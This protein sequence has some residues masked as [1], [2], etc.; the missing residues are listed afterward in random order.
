MTPNTINTINKHLLKQKQ[1]QEKV[2]RQQ[3]RQLRKA[4]NENRVYKEC[5]D[6]RISKADLEVI[7]DKSQHEEDEFGMIRLRK[8]KVEKIRQD[9]LE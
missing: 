9:G 1:D 5:V 3:R 2:I 8:I 7:M 6:G 4:N